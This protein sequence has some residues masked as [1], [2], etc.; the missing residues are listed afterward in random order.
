[1]GVALEDDTGEEAIANTEAV[2]LTEEGVLKRF[3]KP[4]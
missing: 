1:M 4:E 3:M 2:E